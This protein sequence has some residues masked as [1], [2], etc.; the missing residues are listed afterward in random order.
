MNHEE[1]VE[2]EEDPRHR[3]SEGDEGEGKAGAKTSE[4]ALSVQGLLP[5]ERVKKRREGNGEYL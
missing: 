2:D 3:R 5:D 1:V 4:C